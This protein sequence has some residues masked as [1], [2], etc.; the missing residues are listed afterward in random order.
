MKILPITIS[1]KCPSFISKWCSVQKIY[2][3]M[4][5]SSC[6]NA[7]DVTTFEV[8]EMF[9]YVKKFN[10]FGTEYAWLLHDIRKKSVSSTA[11]SEVWLFSEGNLLT[12]FSGSVCNF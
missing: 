5:S 11:F 2:S 4:F 7:H 9:W 3:K 1:I 6:A 10:V 12:T 8:N